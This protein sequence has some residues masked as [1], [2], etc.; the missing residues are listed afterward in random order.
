MNIRELIV[1]ML[2]EIENGKSYSHILIRNVLDKYGYFPAKDR[3]FIKRVTEGTL[4]RRIQID[5]IINAYSKV[6][7]EKMKPLI[8]NLLR[9]SVYQI[10]FMDAVP[11]AAAC[12]EAVKLAAK[13]KF[14]NLKGFVNGV[15][16][17][18]AR[19]KERIGYGCG[20]DKAKAADFYPDSKRNPVAYLSVFYSMPEIIVRIWLKEYG[21][22]QTERML[23]AMLEIRPVTVRIKESLTE[24]EKED[25]LAKIEKKGIGIR[26]HS[27]LPYAYCL[28]HAEGIRSVPGFEE[29]LFAVQD[30]SSMLCVECAGIK[31]GDFV[32]DVCAAP[33]GK[34][35]HGAEKTG[36]TGRVLARDISAQKTAYI[37]ENAKRQGLNIETE[38]ADAMEY[39]EELE[40][41]A[42]VLLA[43]VPCSGLGV[44]GRK[45]DIKYNIT[46]EM[47]AKLPGIQR[48][49][50]DT[51][52]RYVKPGGILVYSTCTIRKEEN[53][54]NAGWFLKNFPFTAED[55]SSRLENVPG[56]ETAQEGYIQLL[57]DIHETDGFF[58]AVFRREKH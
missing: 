38:I 11:D 24:K 22:E 13:R 29:G 51:V 4:E 49:I 33:G 28:D 9:M 40:G 21:M 44:L 8:R 2:I 15:L 39:D 45:R 18:I 20:V 50:L 14:Q 35:T 27:Y 3:A 25:W 55:I 52:W 34:S 47:L 57:P 42:D 1:D 12:N 31:E 48:K 54:E 43:D 23:Q 16:R 19:Q 56:T 17:N 53:E 30:V 46:E 6:P 58:I 41:L 7:A 37:R 26:R 10:L 5:Y 36:K 32:V